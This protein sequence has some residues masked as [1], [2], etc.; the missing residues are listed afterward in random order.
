MGLSLLI[1][2]AQLYS[3]YRYAQTTDVITNGMGTL[4]GVILAA[5]GGNRLWDHALDWT[6][7]KL[8]SEP[9]AL[10]V[11]ALTAVILLGALLPLDLSITWQ[12]IQLHLAQAQWS[13][14]QWPQSASRLVAA[15]GLI[16]QAWLFSFW[17][18]A[19]AHWLRRRR[20]ALLRVVGWGG[21]LAAAAEASQLLVVSQGVSVAEALVAWGGG[22]AGGAALLWGRRAGLSSRALAVVFGTGYI[23]YLICDSISPLAPTVLRAL[24]DRH[25]PGPA[26][27]T[28]QMVPFRSL[29][30]LPK[31]MALGDW[32]ARLARFVPLGAVIRLSIA[33]PDLRLRVS[34]G[35]A[36]VVL[37]LE[38]LV[39]RYDPWHGGDI[40][41][42]VL[43]WAGLATGWWG[44]C[45]LMRYVSILSSSRQQGHKSPLPEVVS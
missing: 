40:T 3:P 44:G 2:S 15:V 12:S 37:L 29:A 27:L 1:E 13:P 30:E 34:L 19:A 25:W 7:G 20:H 35:A 43:A 24:W 4:L 21:V 10:V 31:Y 17:G 36:V 14:L 41:E 9:M 42:V 38:V 22:A 39:A 32:L 28:F 6:R 33:R 16:K 26:S 18:A 23:I 8:L 5:F 11:V 45:F